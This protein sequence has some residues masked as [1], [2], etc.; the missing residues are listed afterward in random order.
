MYGTGRV[1]VSSAAGG[2]RMG[3]H[4]PRTSAEADATAAGAAAVRGEA[5]LKLSSELLNRINCGAFA[6][7]PP[8][9]WCIME[10]VHG[11]SI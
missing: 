2:S 8:F 3:Y 1:V 6:Q 11:P 9:L 4:V 10:H 7:A 5:T